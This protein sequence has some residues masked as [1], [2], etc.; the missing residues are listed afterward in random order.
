LPEEYQPGIERKMIAAYAMAGEAD[1]RRTL[2]GG[3]G[4]LNGGKQVPVMLIIIPYA[5]PVFR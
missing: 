5:T 4:T 1:A 2:L 3:N